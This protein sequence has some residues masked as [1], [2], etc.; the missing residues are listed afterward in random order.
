[1][2]IGNG[3]REDLEDQAQQL[4][5]SFHNGNISYVRLVLETA[6]PALAL[7]VYARLGAVDQAALL[8]CMVDAIA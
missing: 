8:A 4:A 1:M 2:A 3:A 7:L 6:P 5:N